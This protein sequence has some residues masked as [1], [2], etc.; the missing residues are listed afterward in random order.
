MSE[1]KYALYPG[2]VVSQNDGQRH[3]VSHDHLAMLYGVRLSDCLIVT[4]HMLRHYP[5]YKGLIERAEKLIAL[6]PRYDG[7]YKLPPG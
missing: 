2:Y 5:Q 3:F 1:P 4:T 6:R 7:N